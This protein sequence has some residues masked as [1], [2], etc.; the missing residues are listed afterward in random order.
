MSLRSKF[1][2][3]K[4]ALF[5][6]VRKKHFVELNNRIVV[7]TH[8]KAGTV[9]LHNVFLRVSQDLGW[10]FCKGIAA[11]LPEDFDVFAPGNCQI[12]AQQ[13]Q[14]P[15]K[16][17]HM[18]RDPRDIIISGCFYHQKAPEPWLQKK[19]SHFGGL[20][21]QEKLN[22]YQSVDDRILFEMEY[23]ARPCIQEML[24]WNYHDPTFFEVKYEDLMSDEQLLLFHSIFAFLGVPGSAIPRALRIAFENSLFSGLPPITSHI[25]SGKTRQW[26]KY[27]TSHHHSRFIELFGD[28]LQRLGYESSDEWTADAPRQTIP[29]ARSNELS[30]HRRAA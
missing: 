4:A 29:I 13:I 15:F 22:S 12:Q 9:W 25:R 14:A 7:A 20:S 6:F 27:F 17:L 2:R 30:E 11:N 8:H 3:I 19:H 28:A 21:Y 5:P 16:G 10:K 24:A 26:E 1:R 18:I 23:A